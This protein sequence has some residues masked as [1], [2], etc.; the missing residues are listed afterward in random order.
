M[1]NETHAIRADV[2]CREGQTP[3]ETKSVQ[4]VRKSDGLVIIE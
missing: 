4:S 3:Q 2:L 1:R